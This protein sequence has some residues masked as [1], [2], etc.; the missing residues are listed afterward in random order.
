[1]ISFKTFINE[2]AIGGFM[3]KIAACQTLDGIKELEKYYETRKKEIELKQADD[4]SVR[5]ALAGKRAELESLESDD[6][7]EEEEF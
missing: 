7:A 1:M 6:D 4:I 5:D 2:A 3:A